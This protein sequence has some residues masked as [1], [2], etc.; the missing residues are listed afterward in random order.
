[1]LMPERSS[2]FSAVRRLEDAPAEIRTR[3][4]RLKCKRR[5]PAYP[6]GVAPWMERLSEHYAGTCLKRNVC[7][8]RGYDLS[9]EPVVDGI[10]TCP[11]H[12]LR[13]NVGTG[14][15]VQTPKSSLPFTAPVVPGA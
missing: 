7:P 3:Q 8:H 15:C 1:M 11:L 13:W 10:V 6:H 9:R 4:R 14:T 5:L 2:A 12:G